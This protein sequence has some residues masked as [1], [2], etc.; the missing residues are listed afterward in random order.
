MA[1]NRIPTAV[2]TTTTTRHGQARAA[3][4]EDQLTVAIQS[5]RGVITPLVSRRLPQQDP[6]PLG[7]EPPAGAP[8]IA[9]RGLTKRYG[10]VA[11]VQE[12][13][14]EVHAG[15]VCGFLGRN[16]AGKSTTLNMLA[17]LSAPTSGTA[18]IAGV[19]YRSLPQPMCVAGFG[20]NAEAF[21][22]SIGGQRALRALASRIGVGRGRVR[23]VLA[24]VE[25]ES[26]ADRP[27]GKY[28]LGMRQRLLLAAALLGDPQAIVLD[29][30]TNGL[31][32]QGHR[33]L[34]DFLRARAGEGRAVLLSSHVLADVAETVDRIVVISRGRLVADQPIDAIGQTTSVRVRTP[35]A[36]V[37]AGLLA[38]AATSVQRVDPDALNVTGLDIEPIG[39]LAAAHRIV[40]HDLTPTG[41]SLEDLFFELT[42]SEGDG[43]R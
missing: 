37:F 8:M 5:D 2:T 10:S 27:V 42:E 31:D 1:I 21:H 39:E 35:D 7:H 4:E 16:G 15:T 24:L 28:S 41:G 12:L 11:A 32:P 25:L 43:L 13:S 33:W 36:D 6:T 30:P 34:R 26:A 23:E 14:F 40:L 29:E 20:L 17:G 38:G 9:V 18:T 19:P 22:P 3:F